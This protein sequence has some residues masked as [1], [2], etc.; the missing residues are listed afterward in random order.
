MQ[1]DE[2]KKKKGGETGI[3]NDG[4]LALVP[5]PL[6]PSSKHP[7]APGEVLAVCHCPAPRCV[8][9]QGGD[10][11]RQDPFL[12]DVLLPRDCSLGWTLSG[13]AMVGH[14]DVSVPYYGVTDAFGL[15]PHLCVAVGISMGTW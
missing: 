8:L 1:R 5:A 12:P 13:S 6:P 14:A 9:Q 11:G 3:Y 7:V 15:L 4:E 2:N 10:T